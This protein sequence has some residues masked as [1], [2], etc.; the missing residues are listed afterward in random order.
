MT[1][2]SA[3]D[4]SGAE[5]R[6]TSSNPDIL[7]VDAASGVIRGIASGSATVTVQVTLNGVSRQAEYRI[8]VTGQ[9]IVDSGV[10]VTHEL[11]SR[12]TSWSPTQSSDPNDIRGITEEY[13]DGWSF[14]GWSDKL[15]PTSTMFY[16]YNGTYLRVDMNVLGA[17]SAFRINFPEAGRYRS[18]L[19]YNEYT[20]GGAA[21]VYLIP[22]PKDGENVEDYLTDDWKLGSFESLNPAAGSMPV[23]N[24][25]FDDAIIEEAGDYLLVFQQ[26]RISGGRYLLLKAAT[27]SGTSPIVAVT[28]SQG[29]ALEIGGTA[30]VEAS[31][32]WERPLA[33]YQDDLQITY[34]NKTPEILSLTDG[35]LATGL[36]EGV[37]EIQITATSLGYSTIGTCYIAVGSVKARRSYYTD[38]K[39]AN[40]QNNIQRYAWARSTRDAAVK[41]ADKMLG[42]HLD[43]LWEMIPTQELPRASKVGYRSDPG[44]NTCVFC[45]KDLL[46]QY[47]AYAWITDPVTMPWKVQCPDC[48][49]QFPSN[50][51]GAFYKLGVDEHG[52][53]RYQ[54]ALAKNAELVAKGEK[55]YLTNVLY[56]EKKD[57]SWGVDDGWGF[58][59]NGECKSFIACY[60]F[61][62]IWMNLIL[63]QMD[64][65]RDAYLY[66][67]DI[68]YGR[69]GAILV[70]RISD[71]Y[72]DFDATESGAKFLIA[73]GGTVPSR[74]KIG[75]KIN[76][77]NIALAFAQYYDAFWPATFDSQV[78]SF[79]SQKAQK[80]QMENPKASQ[81]HI[82]QNM[83]N[84]LIR[85]INRG[86]RDYRINSNF[87]HHQM[88]HLTAAVALDTMPETKDWIDFTFQSG[89]RVSNYEFD[90]GNVYAQLVDVVDRDGHGN[91]SGPA[92]NTGWVSSMI[93]LA[94]ILNGYDKYPEA[95]LYKN[96]KFI[97]MLTAMT[98]ITAV[99]RESVNVGDNNVMG[100]GYQAAVL[101][102]L[103]RAYEMIGGDDIARMIYIKNGQKLT[104]IYGSIFDAE[105]EAVVQGVEQA[106]AKSIR[107]EQGSRN[108]TGYGLAILRDGDWVKAANS[109]NT[110]DTQRDF[111]IYYGRTSGHG[112][113]DKLTLGVHAYGLDVGADVG[114]PEVKT[115]TDPHRLE[116]IEQTITHNTV[117]VNNTAQS[118]YDYGDPLHFDDA[119]QVK[120][121]DVSAPQAYAATDEYRRTLVMVNASDEVSYGVD[122]FHVRGGNDHNYSFHALGD[123]AE[124]TGVELVSQK[125]EEG[126]YIGSYK[127]VN[128]AWGS[129]GSTNSWFGEVDTAS[130]PGNGNVI[131]MDWKITD[132]Y[133][134]LKPARPGLHL[135]L[136]MLNS[137]LLDEVTMTSGIPP[138]VVGAPES[139]KF[140]FA[141]HTGENDAQAGR[142]SGT[143]DSLF[144]SVVEP[145]DGERYIESIENV[146]VTRL[147]GEEFTMDEAKAVKVTLT[148]G[149]QDYIVYAKDKTV[150]YRVG[151]LFDFRGF[152][153]VVSAV[154]GEISYT[155]LNDGDTIA[156]QQDLLPAVTG[157]VQDFQKEL[158]EENFITVAADQTVDP[159]ELAGQYIY[160]ENGLTD[161]AVYRIESAEAAAE[162]IRLNLGNTT[163]I[164]SYKNAKDFAAG[165]NYN[166]GTGQ[167]FRI[168][169]S[170][171]QDG[172]PVFDPLTV[173]RAT[174]GKA[175]SMQVH[176]T[177]PL[178]LPLQYRADI[179]P[180]GASF[181]ED[182]HTLT[183]TP[184][185]A[186]IGPNIVKFTASDGARESSILGTI[187][188]YQLSGGEGTVAKPELPDQPDQP[189]KPDQPDEPDEPK[190]RFIDLGGYDWAKEAINIL[191][192]KGIVQGTSANTYSPGKNIK[193]ADYAV[194]LTRA[195]QLT[196]GDGTNFTDVGPDAYYAREIAAAKANG[197]IQGVGGGRFAPEEPITRQDAMVILYRALQKSGASARGSG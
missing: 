141:R 148:N 64:D 4:L 80:Y 163:L 102:N 130:D 104:G 73:D 16:Q 168:P 164:T 151:D 43:T 70:D 100:S 131:S 184:D 193:R 36:Q 178:D 171:V 37:G 84:N 172:S 49:R 65:L 5:F 136:T 111:Y 33:E 182:T 74:G 96:P 58:E 143:L 124:L 189:D 173:S 35:N 27:F 119:G 109:A 44:Q 18:I 121:M 82:V 153:G 152:I 68:K 8:R 191:A 180:R 142:G 139:I 174:A 22:V 6:Y 162:G 52:N 176:A 30:R 185:N 95:D 39:L 59:I 175:M 85:E 137:F 187:Q 26:T 42:Y 79:L 3:A 122:F 138:Q 183:W 160:V 115:S 110:V 89:G 12:V 25:R 10:R 72:P 87:G 20:S 159:A 155:Y 107:L 28:S 126:N 77:Y 133:N 149:R 78:I 75:G 105:P 14:Y 71:L 116:F 90:G 181:N 2:G 195:F 134:V 103:I 120:L 117:T 41:A 101:G 21:D 140:L 128:K 125:D 144:T 17:W 114:T 50:D 40:A 23:I 9:A 88:V 147:D 158:S 177:S 196:G 83:E 91:E 24:R 157:T 92:Y 123:T 51:F 61:Q 86:I 7:Q 161:N 54:Q 76:E 135:R 19:E 93:Q 56:P 108:L 179:L 194:L 63:G 145:Y 190:E 11:R 32:Q 146:D 94:D 127:D 170:H 112:H 106:V 31:I 38:Q 150:G 188:V 156:E 129:K 69:M 62:G 57:D 197:I 98:D 60:N 47:G 66:T 118:L 186:Q 132:Y 15:K 154:E 192:E 166:I 29:N 67:N 99:S 113:P 55:G 53:W 45:G 46:S 1:D 81:A 13:T 97:R 165:Y 34:E 48:R 167:S 169:L